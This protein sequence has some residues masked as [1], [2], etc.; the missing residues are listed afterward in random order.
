MY[1]CMQQIVDIAESKMKDELIVL[2]HKLKA[3]RNYVG[4]ALWDC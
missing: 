3:F 1:V 2:A 4:E